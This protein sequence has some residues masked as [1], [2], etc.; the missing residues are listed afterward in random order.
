MEFSWSNEEENFR[1]E[2]REFLDEHWDAGM[3]PEGPNVDNDA[4]KNYVRNF[5]RKL[6]EKGWLTMSWPEEYG[7][8]GASYVQQM[9]FREEGAIVDAPVGGGGE[10]ILAPAIMLNGTEEQKKEYLVPMTTGEVLWSQGYSEPGA[11][12]D[13]ASL[14]TRAVKDGD[15]YI[16]NGQKVWNGAHRG[17]MIHTLVRT[18]PDAPKHRGISYMMIDL[19]AKGV[20]INP[21]WHMN[22]LGR[23]N[24][25]F[26]E[27]VRVPLSNRIGEE[28]RGWYIAVTSLDFERSGIH[29]IIGIQGVYEKLLNFLASSKSNEIGIDSAR[30]KKIYRRLSETTVELEVARLLSYRITSMQ[31]AGIVP[32]YE[33]SMA[34]CLGSELGQ[35]HARR[36]INAVGLYGQLLKNSKYSILNGEI[37]N[38]YMYTVSRTIAGGTSEIQRNIIA[39]RGLGLPRS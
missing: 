29:L 37:P 34:K 27:D 23:F 36:A 17:D 24:E 39:T 5:K 7:G 28:N 25:V 13:L 19:A 20:S 9:I 35:F 1:L 11:G 10:Q 15:G 31:S 33:S 14:Q 22:G 4:A 18:D 16:I 3:L 6:A 32:N 26:F 38:S 21:L 2:V 12:S 8:Q 30:L